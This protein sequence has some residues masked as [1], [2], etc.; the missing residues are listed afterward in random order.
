MR[1]LWRPESVVGVLVVLAAMDLAVIAGEALPPALDRSTAVQ[2]ALGGLGLGAA[3]VPA[4]SFNAFDPRLEPVCEAV[5]WP[6]PGSAC[7]APDHVGPVS[8]FRS[9]ASVDG[10]PRLILRSATRSTP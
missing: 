10:I 1:C 6:L 2:I 5:D 8:H 4:W 9:P 7:Y 3:T